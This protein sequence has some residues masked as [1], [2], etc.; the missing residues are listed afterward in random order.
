MLADVCPCLVCLSV[1]SSVAPC[2]LPDFAPS[3][4]PY[5][6]GHRCSLL[7]LLCSCYLCHACSIHIALLLCIF[8]CLSVSTSLVQC[9]SS[10]FPCPFLCLLVPFSP[11]TERDSHIAIDSSVSHSSNSVTRDKRMLCSL[12]PVIKNPEKSSFCLSFHSY[13]QNGVLHWNLLVKLE[14]NSK[15]LKEERYSSEQTKQ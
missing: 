11:I 7:H 2:S 8:L 4:A 1:S 5:A 15:S 9:P 13:G 12:A 6:F 10:P 3:P 14:R